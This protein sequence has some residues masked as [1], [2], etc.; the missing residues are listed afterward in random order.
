M[1]VRIVRVA[2]QHS[3]H[4]GF[5]HRHGDMGNGIF[6]ESGTFEPIAQRSAQSC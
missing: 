2:M 4:G 6:V 3:I 1:L 5:A